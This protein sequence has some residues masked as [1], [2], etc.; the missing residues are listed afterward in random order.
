M[1]EKSL[2]DRA[3]EALGFTLTRRQF[4]GEIPHDEWHWV[5][6]T[7]Y[8]LNRAKDISGFFTKHPTNYAEYIKPVLLRERIT[9]FTVVCRFRGVARWYVRG[10]DETYLGNSFYGEGETEAEAYCKALLDLNGIVDFTK[11]R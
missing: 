8:I 3:A 11:S 9:K 4:A 2:D 7:G 5:N 6:S 1:T 10:D